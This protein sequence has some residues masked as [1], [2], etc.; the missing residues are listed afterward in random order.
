M[1]GAIFFT[2]LDGPGL[3]YEALHDG[4]GRRT[5]KTVNGQTWHYYWDND[6]LAAELFPDGRLRIYV[7]PDDLA[8]VPILSV[9]YDSV[10]AEPASGKRYHL[11]TDHLG[12]AELVLDDAG[13]TVS[14]RGSPPTEPPTWTW[15][16]ASTSRFVGP[17]TTSTSRPAC[18]RTVSEPT[19]R[20][21]DGTCSRILRVWRVASTS[22]RIRRT[23]FEPSTSAA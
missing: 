5:E 17:V 22:T 18:T 6:R 11:F 4:L 12:C 10:D 1:T 23:L 3:A 2:R 14:E 16:P 19:A 7:Y 9:D 8:W 21:S 20:S 15:G 13:Q